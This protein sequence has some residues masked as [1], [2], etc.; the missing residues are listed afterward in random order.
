MK[1]KII[2]DL[3]GIKKDKK[4]FLKQ[5][6]WENLAPKWAAY[7]SPFRP[8]CEDVKNYEE[9]LKRI[10]R[11]EKVL[12]LGATPELRDIA[13]KMNLDVV[14]ADF[15]LSMVRGMLK[16][17]KYAT[18]YQE[19]WVIADWLALGKFLKTDN[20]F[21][22]ILGDLIL[23]NIEPTLQGAFLEKISN[24]LVPGGFF[25][26]RIH[27]INENL[28]NL[29]S[30]ILIKKIFDEYPHRIGKFLEDLITSRLFDK[31]TDFKQ[32]KIS[33]DFF[34]TDIN[35]FLKNSLRNKKEKSILNNVIR[36]WGGKDTWTQRTSQEVD[37]L[38][39]EN[40]IIRNLRLASDYKDSEFYP[41]YV[42]ENKA[43]AHH[44]ERTTG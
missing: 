8:S 20:C 1:T 36:K 5:K 26:T 23:R 42:L 18:K 9:I 14:V 37:A 39:M 38:L 25:I 28:L 33:K 40:F 6:V 21:D 4:I 13:A 35:N 32:H 43:H 2:T 15:S 19:K 10:G 3:S 16:F 41:I 34:L 24:L 17:G 22:I 12:I 30:A 44:V 11:K 7:A 31:N 27:F 29:N